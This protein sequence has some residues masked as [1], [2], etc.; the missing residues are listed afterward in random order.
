MHSPASTI[1]FAV[2]AK[3]NEPKP[4]HFGLPS[5]HSSRLVFTIPG[6]YLR[7]WRSVNPV[8]AAGPKHVHFSGFG[9]PSRE[10]EEGAPP[11]A[12]WI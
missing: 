10:T 4:M 8:Q 12:F 2:V 11:E 5:S 7:P 6:R 1:H 3:P 9:S